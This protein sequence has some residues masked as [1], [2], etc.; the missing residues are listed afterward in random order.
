MTDT[1]ARVEHRR[2]G[3]N[4]PEVSAIGLGFMSFRTSAGAEDET[5]ATELVA[6]AIDLGVTLFDTADVYGPEFSEILLGKAIRGRRDALTIATKFG[7][8]LDRDTNPDARALDGRPEYVRTAIEG[9]L[10]R[11][12]VDHVDLYYQHRVDP[13]VPIEDTVG[14]LA[15]LVAAGKVRHIGLSEPGPQTLRRAHAV[16]PIAAIQNEWSLFTR[17]IEADTVS[18][19]RELG[20]GIVPYSPLGRGWLTGRVRSV[21]DV[22]GVQS[23]HPRFG[24]DV[25]DHNRAL[26]DTVTEIAAQIGV[27]PSQVALAWVL[28]RGQD[29]VPIPGTRHP[30]FLRE[31]LG[32]LTVA[33][34]A[35]HLD[36]LEAIT[37]QV[38]GHRSIRP[39]HLGVEAPVAS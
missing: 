19:A 16:H 20:I 17:D 9:S 32:A 18:V 1:P 15:E 13:D 34:D 36:R 38:G 5:Q 3:D 6:E 11:L 35:E 24:A 2:L 26:A 23:R 10:R 25:F 30:E 31:N 8:A 22:K 28:S 7:N 33:L 29:V 39:E 14:A 4:G 37:G 12:G 21:E 27:Q